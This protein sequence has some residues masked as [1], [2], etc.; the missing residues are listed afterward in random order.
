MSCN[1]RP[2]TLVVH[3]WVPSVA[4]VTQLRAPLAAARPLLS[5][6][7]PD[8]LSGADKAMNCGVMRAAMMV[9]PTQPSTLSFFA[10]L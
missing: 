8:H 6:K 10:P 3:D 7:M 4:L 5:P 1:G 9:A 2:N